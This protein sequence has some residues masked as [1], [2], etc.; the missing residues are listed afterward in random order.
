[1]WGTDWPLVEGYCGYGKALA[2]VKDE[3]PFLN[4]DDKWWML[5]ATV[6][7]VFRI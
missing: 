3:M 7:R 6:Q 2:I 5:S 1:M 4:E